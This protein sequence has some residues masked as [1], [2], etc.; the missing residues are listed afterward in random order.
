VNTARLG[1]LACLVL[2]AAAFGA[3]GW[4]RHEV[5]QLSIDARKAS[6][7]FTEL[8]EL[9]AKP[10]NSTFKEHFALFEVTLKELDRARVA[11]RVAQPRLAQSAPPVLLAYLESA[12]DVTRSIEK[13][14]RKQFEMRN[15]L[16]QTDDAMADLKSN[17][18]YTRSN[19]LERF[20]RLVDNAT[21]IGKERQEARAQLA[22]DVG[23]LT[24]ARSAAL[25]AAGKDAVFP[26]E[27]LAQLGVLA[28]PPA[29]A[30]SGAAQS[31]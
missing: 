26:E 11:I 8:V 24:Q 10:G 17:N 16:D 3:W 23:R 9:Q 29:L 21:R 19:A 15:T 22:V 18:E 14:T 5:E 13:L 20:T 6:V 27:Q 28:E 12:R 7:Q 31:K 25:A 1:A 4:Q 2:A 30:A